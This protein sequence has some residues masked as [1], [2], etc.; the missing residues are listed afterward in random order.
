ML[1]LLGQ[2]LP[3]GSPKPGSMERQKGLPKT[4]LNKARAALSGEGFPCHHLGQK[5]ARNWHLVGK[6]HISAQPGN[7]G[8]GTAQAGTAFCGIEESQ[9][10]KIP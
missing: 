5:R 6:L 9:A 4:G 8:I 1:D 3:L 10:G 2:I 7:S